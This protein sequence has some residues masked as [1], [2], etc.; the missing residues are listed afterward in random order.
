MSARSGPGP[1]SGPCEVALRPCTFCAG[2]LSEALPQKSLGTVVRFA[3]I[4]TGNLRWRHENF[5]SFQGNASVDPPKTAESVRDQTCAL[6]LSANILNSTRSAFIDIVYSRFL[7]LVACTPNSV[8][9]PESQPVISKVVSYSKI[10]AFT[11]Q[12][13]VVFHNLSWLSGGL[14][15]GV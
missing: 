7:K 14:P 12:S 9:A 10:I 1:G 13:P 2:V 5:A 6:K 8:K 15:L 3:A 11:V 4:K